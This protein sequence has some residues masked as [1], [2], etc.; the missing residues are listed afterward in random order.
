M[1]NKENKEIVQSIHDII[2]ESKLNKSVA[3]EY[4]DVINGVFAAIVASSSED[5]AVKIA[6]IRG[7]VEID[8][9]GDS[10]GWTK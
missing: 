7:M 4:S 3:K 5:P 2:K 8:N 9:I 1:K 6:A 10:H